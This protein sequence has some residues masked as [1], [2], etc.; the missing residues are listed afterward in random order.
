MNQVETWVSILT[1]RAIRR[2]SFNGV[3]P[4]RKA[5]HAFI[6]QWHK[7]VHP[8]K[9]VKNADQILAKAIAR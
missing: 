1:R 8:L 4:L 6:D 2:G 7:E 5:I 3:T 9:W